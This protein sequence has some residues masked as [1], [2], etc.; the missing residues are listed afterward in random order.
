MVGLLTSDKR[1][2]HYGSVILKSADGHTHT[3]EVPDRAAHLPFRV[4]AGGSAGI[5]RLD[6]FVLYAEL[7]QTFWSSIPKSGIKI[8]VAL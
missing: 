2:V 3:H 5:E 4:V 1:R 8:I 6:N 7:G